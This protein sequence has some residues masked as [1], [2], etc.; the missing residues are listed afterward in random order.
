MKSIAAAI[1]SLSALCAGAALAA[2]AREAMP[3]W[4]TVLPAADVAAGKTAAVRCLSCHDTSDQKINQFGPPLWNVVNRPRATAPAFP[5]SDAMK[6]SHAPWSYDLLFAYL[7]DPQAMVHGTP[8]SFAG[9]RNAKQRINVIA[10]LRTLSDN[11]APLPP[12]LAAAAPAGKKAAR[13]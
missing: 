1:L 7:K 11:P 3:D 2:P 6:A 10:Y 5:Y 13:K 9:F 12:P 4:G 8:M